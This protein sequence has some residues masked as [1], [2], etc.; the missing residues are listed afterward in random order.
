MSGSIHAA[1]KGSKGDKGNGAGKPKLL[2]SLGVKK[3]TLTPAELRGVEGDSLLKTA[4]SDPSQFVVH[5]DNLLAFG[6]PDRWVVLDFVAS[7]GDCAVQVA[8]AKHKDLLEA[9]LA[10]MVSG[11]DLPTTRKARLAALEVTVLKYS[12]SLDVACSA[13]KKRMKELGYTGVRTPELK[14]EALEIREKI[15]KAIKGAQQSTAVTVKS[16]FPSAPVS[17]EIRVPSGWQISTTGVRAIGCAGGGDIAAP[18]LITGVSRDV[19]QGHELVTVAWCKD[20]KWAQTTVERKV[21]ANKNAVLELASHGLPIHSGNTGIL[22]KYLH[23]F[24]V[25][26]QALLATTKLSGQMGWQGK[27]GADGFLLGRTLITAVGSGDS[28]PTASAGTGQVQFRGAD[29]GDDQLAAGFH[30]AGTLEAWLAGIK[31]IKHYPRVLLGFYS[32]FV[33]PML[34]I[35]GSENFAL[36]FSGSTS[37]GKTTTLRVAAS[38]WGKPERGSRDGTA[39]FDWNTTPTWRERASAVMNHIPLFLDDSKTARHPDEISQTVYTYTQ[40]RSRGRGTVQGLAQQVGFESVLVSSGER[41][42]IS[43][44]EHGGTRPRVLTL[45]GSPFG[46]TSEKTGRRVVKINNCVGAN[47]GHAAP[48]FIEYL[49]KKRHRWENY[50]EYHANW[51]A[52]FTKK[53]GDNAVAGRMAAHFAAIVYTSRLVHYALDLP[54]EWSDPISPLYDDLTRE[55]AEADRAAAALRYAMGWAVSHRSNFFHLGSPESEQPHGGWAGR[56]DHDGDPPVPNTTP[57]AWEWVGF[58]PGVLTKVLEDGGF[59]VDPS[60]RTWKDRGWLKVDGGRN[61]HKVKIVG[62]ATWVVAV[63]RKGIEAAGAA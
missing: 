62:E 53:A 2:L 21:I 14:K 34:P 40:G 37:Q 17:D 30:T 51:T 59:E 4:K 15:D 56:W 38:V 22:V 57:T 13:I 20:G 1:K 6:D 47:Y 25:V 32:A 24:L 43:F 3:K 12:D 54:W 61:Q 48:K 35:F 33:P 5:L 19:Q 41:P 31:R 44:G 26:N 39:L 63:T 7:L 11:L 49:L 16:A 50:R 8:E 45:W 27:D 18:V 23:D 60:I 10:G 36:D 46:G 58:I 28:I 9:V 42:V 55:V 29:S 52:E